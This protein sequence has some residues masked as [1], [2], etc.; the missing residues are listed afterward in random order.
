MSGSCTANPRCWPTRRSAGAATR[1][2]AVC[3]KLKDSVLAAA[4]EQLRL[5]A[6]NAR[7]GTV[8]DT[9]RGQARDDDRRRHD[10]HPILP[11]ASRLTGDP[12]YE[13]VARRHAARTAALLIRPDGSTIQAVNFNR[14]TGRVVSKATHQGI[15]ERSTWSRGQGWGVYGFT[16]NAVA[17]HSR[18][19]LHVAERLADYVA[20]HLP[21]DGVP[22]WDYDAP[23]GAPLD[24]S[25]GVITSAGLFHLAAACQTMHGVCRQSPAV[26]RALGAADAERGARTRLGP[27][28]ARL[29]GWPGARR[30]RPGLLV[31]RGGADV[32]A[33]SYALEAVGLA[34]RT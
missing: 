4:D 21:S 12:R 25:A 27:V 22:R 32:R 24:V 8:P 33:Q 15:S 30:A 17:L 1:D 28:A 3:A 23:S 5:A 9:P 10:E 13:R 18:S 16:V 19:L 20:G 14:R 31:Q 6:T 34:R 11:W 7:A 2:V 29:P 26:W